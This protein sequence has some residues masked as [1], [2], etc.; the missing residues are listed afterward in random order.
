MLDLVDSLFACFRG[1]VQ[2]SL[3]LIFCL[4]AVFKNLV[5]LLLR[6]GGVLL[7]DFD[8]FSDFFFNL[9]SRFLACFS[10]LLRLVL[11]GFFGVLSRFFNGL[12]GV[13]D[14]FFC[15]ICFILW[16]AVASG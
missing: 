7:N 1:G 13:G 8:F 2:F 12:C 16:L 5:E 11:N 10:Q 9:F 6:F 3:G 15:C 14:R 4:L